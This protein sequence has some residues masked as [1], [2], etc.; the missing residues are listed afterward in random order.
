MASLIEIGVLKSKLTCRWQIMRRFQG[1][2]QSSSSSN[3]TIRIKGLSIQ[4]LSPL[5]FRNHRLFWIN[6]IFYFICYSIFFHFDITQYISKIFSHV[7]ATMVTFQPTLFVFAELSCLQTLL[8]VVSQDVD[9]YHR[10][11]SEKCHRVKNFRHGNII[12]HKVTSENL[13]D[14]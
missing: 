12:R 7:G 13:Q 9:E 8:M 3:R 5:Y 1:M 6:V 2:R 14:G 10:V 4:Q 11:W